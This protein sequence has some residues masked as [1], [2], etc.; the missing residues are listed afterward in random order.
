MQ[1]GST[2]IQMLEGLGASGYTWEH[3]IEGPP[4]VLSITAEVVTPAISPQLTS[5]NINYVYK[6]IAIKPGKAIIRFCLRRPW[7]S[8]KPPMREVLLDITVV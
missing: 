8:H 3:R 4:D 1:T 2:H 5:Y 6:I 7:E